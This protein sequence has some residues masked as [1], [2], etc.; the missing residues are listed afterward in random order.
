MLSKLVE[1]PVI[2]DCKRI[3]II[4]E[5]S[6]RPI[7]FSLSSAAHVIQILKNARKLREVEGY[8]SI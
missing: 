7:K 8:G 3:G 6:I 2:Q 5:N 1:K 4:R